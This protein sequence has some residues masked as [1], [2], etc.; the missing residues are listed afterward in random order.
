MMF[1]VVE[2]PEMAHR[3]RLLVQHW[4]SDVGRCS[5]KC[6][7]VEKGQFITGKAVQVAGIRHTSLD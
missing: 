3:S 2:E 4:R 6:P 7:C 1:R 5:S